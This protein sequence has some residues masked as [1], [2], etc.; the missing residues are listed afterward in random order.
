MTPRWLLS[1]A[2]L[3]MLVQ[4]SLSFMA[5]MVL[6]VAAPAIAEALDLSPALVG[7]YSVFL[8][9]IAIFSALGCGAFIQRYGPM[10]VSQGALIIMGLG[11]FLATAATLPMF[12]LSAII[13]GGSGA[14]ST[15]AS[16]DLLARYAPPRHAPVIFAIKQTGV[17]LGGILAGILVPIFVL[18]FDWR[19]AFIASG[20][21]CIV[22]AFALQP[23]RDRFDGERQS[24]RSLMPTTE[25][26]RTLRL[27]IRRP[28]TRKISFA[29]FTFVGAQAIFAAFFVLF[30]VEGLDYEL[31]LAGRVFAISQVVA[32]V[33]RILWGWLA[34]TI[35]APRLM[36]ALL[37]LG[38][39]VTGV[40]TG[41]ITDDWSIPLVGFAACAFA[42][43]AVSWHGVLLAEVA[44]LA[45]PGQV[46]SLTGG[47]L[48]LGYI[49]M[50]AYP[51]V[52]GVM[53]A[54]DGDFGY[55]FILAG[56]PA[57][58]AGCLLLRRRPRHATLHPTLDEENT[59]D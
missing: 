53:L 12:V 39:S 56:L 18:A 57:L 34:S 11:L 52:Y 41:L 28:E 7:A 59:D 9:S 8:Y 13:V 43:T 29:M 37:G 10:R 32:V 51:A 6:P 2:V 21:M 5:T 47:V 46:G 33:A 1:L 27:V 26:L 58:I 44:R 49:A 19:G 22:A 55:G 45:P 42:A 38:I 17:P 36:L 48:S 20:L 40:L 24:D 30:L 23:M 31:T 16:S 25:I 54:G 15:P 4:Q 35:I 14:I 50:M 3:T